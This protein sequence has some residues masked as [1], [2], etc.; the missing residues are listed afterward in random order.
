[1]KKGGE[2]CAQSTKGGAWRKEPCGGDLAV[3]VMADG[4]LAR[5]REFERAT[6]TGS[7]L[8]QSGS[9]KGWEVAPASPIVLHGHRRPRLYRDR[10]LTRRRVVL[11]SIILP[12]NILGARGQ[13]PRLRRQDARLGARF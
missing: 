6:A 10:N 13:S 3:F 5:G 12:L 11:S 4:A 8:S 9:G 2:G 1:M 7:E